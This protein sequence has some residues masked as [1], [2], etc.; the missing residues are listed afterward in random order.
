MKI[1]DRKIALIIVTSVIIV[2]LI[3]SLVLV[4]AGNL[5]TGGNS[6]D[7]SANGVETSYSKTMP[8]DA[9]GS[10]TKW[11]IGV[12][13]NYDGVLKDGYLDTDAANE[14]LAAFA[15]GDYSKV[16]RKIQD[17]FYWSSDA[18]ADG[19]TVDANTL[20]AAGY[21]AVISAW[22]LRYTALQQNKTFSYDK[23]LVYVDEDHGAVVIPAEAW[24]GLPAELTITVVWTGSEWKIDGAATSVPVTAKV[25]AAQLQSMTSS[26]DSK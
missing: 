21:T 12:L 22:Q 7:S 4:I 24:C 10:A 19:K 23:N 9:A 2:A 26:S 1:K 25:R 13:K 18:G 14:D 16:P 15:N 6:S 11:F 3:V 5:S 8:S 17:A 20:K